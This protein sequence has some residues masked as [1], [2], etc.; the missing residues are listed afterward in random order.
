MGAMETASSA[1]GPG[2]LLKK[3]DHSRAVIAPLL[4]ILRFSRF[5][6]AMAWAI[7]RFSSRVDMYWLIGGDLQKLWYSA[8]P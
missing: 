6:Q 2:V 8:L 4:L 1:Q 5:C 3:P 7:S